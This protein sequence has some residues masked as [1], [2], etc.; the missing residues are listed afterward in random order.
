MTWIKR[1]MLTCALISTAGC[2]TDPCGWVQP[3]RPSRA[4][5]LSE[6]TARQILTH[7]LTTEKVCGK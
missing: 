6:G 2:V 5:V 7:N 3:I 1:A 4:D